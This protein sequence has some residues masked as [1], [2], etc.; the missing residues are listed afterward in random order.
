MI[1]RNLGD[2]QVPTNISRLETLRKFI[3]KLQAEKGHD[4]ERFLMGCKTVEDFAKAAVAQASGLGL[5]DDLP[6]PLFEVVSKRDSLAVSLR[7]KNTGDVGADQ[8]EQAVSMKLRMVSHTRL[9]RGL[10]GNSPKLV[11]NASDFFSDIF[12]HW[13]HDDGPWGWLTPASLRPDK[14]E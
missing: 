6:Q 8:H 11:K 4:L 13:R 2:I 1:L 9:S 14:W 7:R 3:E 10:V 12:P 5:P